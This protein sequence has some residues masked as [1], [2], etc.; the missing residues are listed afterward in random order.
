M[1]MD[2]LKT[3]INEEFYETFNTIFMKILKFIKKS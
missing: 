2:A 1:L 3:F